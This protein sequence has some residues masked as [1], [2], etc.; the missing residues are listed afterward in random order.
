MESA[1]AGV[2]GADLG[3]NKTFNVMIHYFTTYP[4]FSDRSKVAGH[5]PHC[6]CRPQYK[7]IYF[8][9]LFL[10][11]HFS[12]KVEKRSHLLHMGIN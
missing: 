9:E 3:Y 12:R 2:C 10:A 5:A 11:A 6:V 1:T 7:E 8:R 4:C